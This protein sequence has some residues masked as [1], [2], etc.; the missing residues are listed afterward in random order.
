MP[1]APRSISLLLLPLLFACSTTYRV[2]TADLERLKA[3]SQ[4]RELR[5]EAGQSVDLTHYSFDYKVPGHKA[6]QRLSGIESL[7]R[8]LEDKSLASMSEI[9]AVPGRGDKWWQRVLLGGGVGAIAG[10]SIGYAVT[11][12]VA[13]ERVASQG[14]N[15]SDCS[16]GLVMGGAAISAVLGATVG[17]L[18]AY[19]AGTGLGETEVAS[20]A[21]LDDPEP[22]LPASEPT[23]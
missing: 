7:N 14:P 16:F 8:T 22:S 5:D 2:A 1:S 17:S 9:S 20:F 13:L 6:A 18:V 11:N 23:K 15:C 3:G 19:F 10:F 4:V 21:Y 12:R